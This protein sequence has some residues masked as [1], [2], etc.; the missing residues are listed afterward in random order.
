MV[1]LS[2]NVNS[3]LKR[4]RPII[5]ILLSLQKLFIQSFCNQYKWISKQT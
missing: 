4:I 5:K 2:T 1:R 3:T